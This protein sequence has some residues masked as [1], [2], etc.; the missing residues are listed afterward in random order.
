MS[1]IYDGLDRPRL[2][3]TEDDDMAATDAS[4]S[5]ATVN[6][7]Y[8][9][10]DSVCHLFE[11]CLRRYGTLLLALQ[12][13]PMRS[14]DTFK[15]IVP[16]VKDEFSRL[17][18]WGEQSYA[19]LPQ[20]A[21]RSLDEQLR[22][23]NDT[24]TIVIGSLRRLANHVSKVEQTEKYQQVDTEDE[25]YSS[26]SDESDAAQERVE[27][28]W[29]TRFKKTIAKVF[30]NIRSLYRISDLLRRPRNSSKYLRSSNS[31]I[32]S[33]DALRDTLDY[34]HVSEKIRQWRHLT[35]R[36]R[37]G[38]NEERVV[39]ESEVQLRKKN[40]QR[41][42]ADI[43]FFCQRLTW[44]NLFR[45][46]QFDYWIDYPDVPETQTKPFGAVGKTNQQKDKIIPV[47]STSLSTVAKSALGN[48]TEV[49]QSRTVYAKE[50]NDTRIDACLICSKEMSLSRLYE[51]LAT[52]MEEIALFVLPR[53]PDEDEDEDG[54]IKEVTEEEGQYTEDADIASARNKLETDAS[55]AAH[56]PVYPRIRRE[57]LDTETLE[58]Y[59]V[60]WEVDRTDRDFVIVL[61]E[62]D[63]YETDVLFE[64]TRRRRQG[65]KAMLA[66]VAP[67]E[68][69]ET[70]ARLAPSTAK[71]KHRGL[72][73]VSTAQPHP[74][75]QE[76]IERQEELHAQLRSEEIIKLEA[77]LR[78]KLKKQATRKIE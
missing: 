17:R 24:K 6:A 40:E 49:G 63:K 74:E 36:S 10:N 77:A 5:G 47:I 72:L 35:M 1:Y 11:S 62:L 71:A 50:M 19:V 33:Q 48:N 4:H 7:S 25:E 43:A 69:D 45:R 14:S 8:P 54:Y 64:H 16:E 60:P 22:E 61:C 34:A 56:A 26:L 68:A 73:R 65:D 29:M 41:E 57:F 18:I 15:V 31:T 78:A 38:G 30:E 67:S 9:D 39:T 55:K 75:T 27:S 70:I 3:A 66:D 76:S 13:E 37:V 20:N 21:R 52:H 51:H 28:P 53:N 59:L 58:H 2:K 46:E 42:I 44:A 12:S 23:D 32:P